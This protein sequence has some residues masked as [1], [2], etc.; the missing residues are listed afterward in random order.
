MRDHERPEGCPLHG[1]GL[2]VESLVGRR[3][4]EVVAAWQE[5]GG[6]EDV[7]PLDVWL[8]DEGGGSVHVTTGSDWCLV[9]EAA[10]PDAGYDMGASGRIRVDA[11]DD[12]T[13]FSEYVGECV[14]GV[15]EEHHPNTGRVA[16]ELVFRS[17]RVR[18][19]SRG[20]DLRL[21]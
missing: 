5:A 21:T 14:V 8:I 10:Q 11:A 20:G 4:V 6:D 3:L 7:G 16:L 9:V 13:P 15:R 2:R 17:G 18:C 12:E 1:G 19:A